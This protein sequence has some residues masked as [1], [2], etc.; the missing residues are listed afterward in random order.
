[1]EDNLPDQATT[2]EIG[3]PE[4]VFSAA[5][6]MEG[7]E[8]RL[9]QISIIHRAELFE[10]P[11]GSKEIEFEGVLLDTNRANAWWEKSFDETGGGE[12]PDC[13]SLDGIHPDMNSE[14]LQAAECNDRVCERNQFGSAPKGGGKACKNMKRAH[15][16]IDNSILPYRLTLPPTSIRPMDDYIQMITDQGKPYQVFIT[17]FS[18]KPAKSKAGIEYSKLV[19]TQGEAIKDKAMVDDIKRQYIE[20]KPM[21]R[22]QK[23]QLDEYV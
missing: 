4:G 8:P 7:V 23:I 14:K 5:D 19:L 10:M 21:M 3:F 15:I 13:S 1:M 20:L 18:L 2:Q 9:P 16:L 12:L 17:H 22:G 6:N 11:D